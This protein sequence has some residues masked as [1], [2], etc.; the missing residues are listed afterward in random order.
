MKVMKKVTKEIDVLDCYVCDVC[1][2]EMTAHEVCK[3]TGGHSDWDNDS[4][5]SIVTHE[6]C[7]GQCVLDI[8]KM[9]Y[10]DFK[11]YDS[12]E[13]NGIPIKFIGEMIGIKK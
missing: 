7:S 11:E 2:K 1:E 12:A 3:I 4:S 10:I 6:V 13:I 5:E 9:M 8:M